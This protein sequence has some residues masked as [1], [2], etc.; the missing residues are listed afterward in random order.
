MGL[1]MSCVACG[2]KKST[3]STMEDN[4]QEMAANNPDMGQ[5]GT[6]M[7]DGS[8]E[9]T[10]MDDSTMDGNDMNDSEEG[11][12]ADGDGMTGDGTEATIAPS[13]KN[14][15]YL[16][17][18][19]KLEMTDLQIQ[20]F[21]GALTEFHTRQRNTPS[22]EMLGSLSDERDRQLK[23]ILSDEQFTAYESWKN[24]N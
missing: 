15:D 20:Q 7:E 19:S 13:N 24:S 10:A 18:Y 5:D 9:D 3:Q 11:M 4:Q 14:I 22:G 8:M 21:E 1:I 2:A 23:E 17:M 16:D 12:Q 6:S